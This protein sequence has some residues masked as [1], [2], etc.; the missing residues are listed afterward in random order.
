MTATSGQPTRI[1]GW[2]AQGVFR[3]SVGRQ[4]PEH[5]PGVMIA[6]VVEQLIPESQSRGRKSLATLATALGFKVMMILDLALT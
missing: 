3:G 6:V 1:G 5:A 4:R 2:R